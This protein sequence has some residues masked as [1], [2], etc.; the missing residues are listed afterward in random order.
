MRIS[1]W[2]SDVC[3]SDLTLV[4]SLVGRRVTEPG[5]LRPTTRSPVLV[6]NP[7]DAGWFGQ[8]RIL[9]D[10]ERT[11][12][13]TGDPSALQ[14]APAPTIPAGLAVLDATAPDSVEERHSQLDAQ[15]LR[16]RTPRLT[17]PDRQHLRR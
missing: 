11:E 4:N 5:V 17:P 10:L 15:L 8:D 16:A 6:H 3:S 1:D 14:L 12:R 13:A 9:P 2:S 7:A